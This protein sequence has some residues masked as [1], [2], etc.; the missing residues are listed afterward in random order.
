MGYNYGIL[1][2]AIYNIIIITIQGGSNYIPQH[3]VIVTVTI[4]SAQCYLYTN[5][6]TSNKKSVSSKRDHVVGQQI[7]L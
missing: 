7:F 5:L 3:N 4:F 2:V 1:Y 6:S